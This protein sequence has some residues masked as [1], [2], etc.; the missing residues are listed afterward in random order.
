MVPPAY[1]A[2]ELMQLAQAKA[3]CVLHHHQGG[4]GDVYPHFDY[5]G[6]HQQ[7]YLALGEGFHDGLLVP[8]FLFAVDDAH[9]QVR[10]NSLL[11]FCPVLF[12]GFQALRVL[13]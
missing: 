8:G 13:F 11:E 3:V 7:V 10:E 6:C 12:R 5:G 4:V 1:P 2:P 9:P